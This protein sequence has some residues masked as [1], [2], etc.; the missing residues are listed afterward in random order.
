MEATMRTTKSRGDGRAGRRMIVLVLRVLFLLLPT[1]ARAGGGGPWIYWN[2]IAAGGGEV[3]AAGKT[4]DY[5]V[6]QPFIGTYASPAVELQAGFWNSLTQW[7]L[8]YLPII[9]KGGP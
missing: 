7:A 6:G 2:V 3:Q 5:T 1:V 9:N 4:L 8:N